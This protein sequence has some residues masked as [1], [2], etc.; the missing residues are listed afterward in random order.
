M[1]RKHTVLAASG[2]SAVLVAGTS[3]FAFA[4]GIFVSKPV[5]RVGRL[6]AIS[7]R[8]VPATEP[9]KTAPTSGAPPLRPLTHRQLLLAPAP[10]AVPRNAPQEA[11]VLPRF[12]APVGAPVSAPVVRPA[13]L[14]AVAH[15]GP[16]AVL[17]ARGEDD[18]ESPEGRESDD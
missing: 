10:S 2:V 17:T 9:V 6:Q 16:S 15:S 18:H 12:S 8:L 1:D 5:A 13:V 4:S 3:A 7:A 14:R 11:R